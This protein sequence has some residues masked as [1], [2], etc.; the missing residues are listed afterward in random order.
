MIKNEKDSAFVAG[1]VTNEEGRSSVENIKPGNY[2]LSVSFTGFE[3]K[4]Q[5]LFT[6]SLSAFLD[7]PVIELAEQSTVLKGVT[8]TAK[9]NDISSK[10]DKKTYSVADNISQSGGSVLQSMQNLPGT[11]VQD[12]KVQLRGNDKVTILIG[13]KQ[14]ALT[15]FGSQTGLDNIP[16]SVI[17]KIEIINN[18]SSKYDAN[19]N[20]GIINIIMKKNKQSGFNGKIGFTTG[21]GSL[22][23]RKENLP[24]IRPQYTLTP[25]I[26]P[27]LSLNYRKDKVNI[28]LQ[29]D[30]LHTLTLNKNEFITRV[31]DDGTIINSQLK[32]N[33]NTN[34]LTT[35]AGVDWNLAI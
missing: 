21:L 1:T 31:C 29:A 25:K 8:I 34:F 15:G 22:W 18:P 28:F 14:T 24:T 20:A 6:G 9:T 23:V 19:G 5:P 17:D 11:T 16:A 26:N 32:R 30:D 4:Q 35:K 12:G 27:S 7:T 2:L 3:T 10:L 33:R 13:G